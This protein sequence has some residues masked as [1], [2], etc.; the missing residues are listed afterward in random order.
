MSDI[1][2]QVQSNAIASTMLSQ[3]AQAAG[4]VDGAAFFP[5]HALRFFGVSLVVT[6]GGAL[7]GQTL[8]VT[9]QHSPDGTNWFD[10]A[11]Y[12]TV[13]GLGQVY[14]TRQLYEANEELH[15]DL[16]IPNASYADVVLAAGA[17]H[18]GSAA[19]DFFPVGNLRA[20][21]VV[22]GAVAFAYVVL[23]AGVGA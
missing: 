6:A 18:I 5:I 12:A 19:G 2:T 16:V 13:G 4:T 22:V 11:R 8:D 21:G 17:D 23:L 1:S 20:R 10:W 9:L 14:P 3:T 15:S 7:A